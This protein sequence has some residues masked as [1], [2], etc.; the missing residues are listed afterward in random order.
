MHYGKMFR[1]DAIHLLDKI[2]PNLGHVSPTSSFMHLRRHYVAHLV[3]AAVYSM[4][5]CNL[6][7][8]FFR[9]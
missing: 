2:P 1:L 3:P 9:L 8:G 5:T 6:Y 4:T 7:I